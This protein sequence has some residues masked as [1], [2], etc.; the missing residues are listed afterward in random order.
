MIVVYILLFIVFVK[1]LVE[2]SPFHFRIECSFVLD[3]NFYFYYIFFGYL[4]NV[5]RQVLDL[6]RVC[7]VYNRLQP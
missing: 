7:T 6:D 3:G 2:I 4:E 1:L 5:I